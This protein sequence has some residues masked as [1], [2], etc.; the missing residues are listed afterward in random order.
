MFQ[1]KGAI[2]NITKKSKWDM[3]GLYINE[4]SLLQLISLYLRVIGVCIDVISIVDFVDNGWDHIYIKTTHKSVTHHSNFDIP[5]VLHEDC[6][7]G[8]KYMLLANLPCT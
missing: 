3:S 5:C 7:Y 2:F 1:S 4:I 8:P 6:P